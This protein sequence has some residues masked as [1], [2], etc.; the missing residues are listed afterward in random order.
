MTFFFPNDLGHPDNYIE[1]NPMVDAGAYRSRMVFLAVLRACCAPIPTK[2]MGVIAM[3]AA[4]LCWSGLPWL[5]TS[6]VKS[7]A[8][9][10]AVPQGS[11]RILV[12]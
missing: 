1:A 2:L 5:D 10:A 4:V 3:F 11:S 8:L 12:V 6:Q 9:S 7:G